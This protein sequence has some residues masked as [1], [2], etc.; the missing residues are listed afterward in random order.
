MAADRPDRPRPTPAPTMDD[1]AEDRLRRE[2]DNLRDQVNDLPEAYEVQQLTRDL[3]T[4]TRN[5]DTAT[6][7]LSELRTRADGLDE[8]VETLEQDLRDT[9]HEHTRA[10]K[11]LREQMQHLERQVRTSAGA[12]TV[13]LATTAEL[14]ALAERAERGKNLEAQQLDSEH[15][16]IKQS[17]VQAWTDWQTKQTRTYHAVVAASRSIAETPP[18]ARNRRGAIGAYRA[19]RSELVEL[20][21]RRD[22]T[23][24]AAN[25]AQSELDD[26]AERASQAAADI[27]RGQQAGKSLRTKLRTQ[28]TDAIEHGHLLPVWFTTVLGLGPP[29]DAEHWLQTG[30]DL[31][32]Y[33]ATYAITDPVVA[34]GPSPGPTAR[35]AR[36]R[37]WHSTLTARLQ[38]YR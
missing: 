26:D 35:S 29:A 4:V 8:T 14:R 10:L 24:T 38:R 34:L 17:A 20:Q 37:D 16:A 12:I 19:A 13:D 27:T 15:R 6:E 21:N 7:D 5:L 36:R 3:G 25:A 33:R 32:A 18:S 31:L 22:Y 2:I 9:R 11:S 23:Q 30:V 1:R 28:L